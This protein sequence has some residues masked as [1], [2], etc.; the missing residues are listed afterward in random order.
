MNL[1]EKN[2]VFDKLRIGQIAIAEK[3][4]LRNEIPI[5]KETLQRITDDKGNTLAFKAELDMVSDQETGILNGAV[6]EVFVKVK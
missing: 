5:K 6:A 2:E 3:W 1:K 4:L